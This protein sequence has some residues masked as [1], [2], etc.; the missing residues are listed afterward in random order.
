MKTQGEIHVQLHI[1][2]PSGKWKSVE[3]FTL[4][5]LYSRVNTT[6]THFMRLR[7]FQSISGRCAEGRNFWP[8]RKPNSDFSAVQ[9]VQG[10]MSAKE[11]EN[12]R[13]EKIGKKRIKTFAKY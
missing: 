2:N 1:L 4:R 13:N 7:V 6:D 11:K 10:G 8:C 9:S 3:S 5:C 12:E